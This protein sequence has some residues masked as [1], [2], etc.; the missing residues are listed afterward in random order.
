MNLQHTAAEAKPDLPLEIAHLLL[1]DV[2]GF[3]KLLVNEQIEVLQELKRIVRGTD[4]FRVAEAND[5]LIRVATGDGMALSFFQSPEEP[6]RCALDISKALL[7]HPHIQLRMGIHSGPINRVRDVNDKTNIVGSGINVAQRVLDCGDAGHI[8]LS[9]HIAEDLAEYRHWQP[10]LHDLGECEVKHGL[11][12]HLFN[13]YKDGLGN[14]QVPEKLKRRMW[15]QGPVLTPLRWPKLLLGTA[16]IVSVLALAMSVWFSFHREAKN[17]AE[18]PKKGATASIPEKS[19]AVLPFENFS[20]DKENA[21]FADG[22]HDEVLTYLAKVADLKV[23]SRTSVM[24]YKNAAMRN[25]REIA[26]QLGVANVLEGSVQRS[27]NRVR[28]TAQL[29]DARTD[30]HVWAERYDRDLADVFAIQSEIAKKIADQLQAKMSLSEK[31]AI[32]KAPTMDLVAYDLYLRA[33]AL[34]ADTT[35]AVHAREKLPQAAQLLDEALMRD[36]NFLQAWCLLSRVHSVAYF[37]GHDHTPARLDLAKAALEHAMRLQPDAGEVH[38][39]LANY[40]YHGFRDYKRA[41]SELTLARQTLPNNAD[42]FLYTGFI[43]RR[44]GHWE[45]ATRNFERAVELDPR[46][47]FILQQLALVYGWQRRYADETRTY[48]R[49]LTIVPADPNTRI[50]Q[51]QVALDWRADIT[52]FQRML[53]ALVAED[54][55][56]AL[57]IDMLLYS[58][59]DRTWAAATRMLANYPR[60]GAANNGVNYPY[61][62]WQGVV[63][64]CQGDSAQA[65][66][67]FAAARTE[68]Q[69]IVEQ[70]PDFAAALSLLGMIDAGLDK[71]EEAV[72]EGQ[73]ACELLPISKDA[74]DGTFLAINLAQIYAWIGDKD[75]AVEQIAALERV[76]NPLSYGLLKLH[77]DWDSLRGDPRFEKIVAS[78]APK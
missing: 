4:C 32:E 65:R 22:I 75:H 70:Q 58:L 26:Q 56:V 67:A 39:A 76:P 35:D 1:I 21:F 25:V 46:N 29:I 49:A 69:K 37:R 63:A 40:Y 23:I 10:C 14:P 77:P 48:D 52:P 11:R 57:D 9:A 30:T 72:R 45:E 71:K 38:L 7:Q 31:A 53:A 34:F 44:E 8:L 55:S 28:V 16:L 73:R 6:V 50:Q 59:C 5:K 64:R 17:I 78:L 12:L 54:P 41:R 43:D 47:F 33:Q 74:I 36:P 68:V 62:Y 19:I 18:V 61:A 13:L 15:K 60:E 42:V 3:S 27:G 20:T 2:V 66:S 51:A 24:Q